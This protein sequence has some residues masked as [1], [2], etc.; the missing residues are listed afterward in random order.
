[1]A[2]NSTSK[3]LQI[4]KANSVMIT[5]V[6][7]TSFIVVFSLVA[8]KAL[9]SQRGYQ[10]RVI[11]KKEKAR[12]QLKQNVTESEKLIASYKSFVSTSQNIIGGNPNGT[13]DKD[14][15]SAK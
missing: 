7:I 3:K 12:D 6:A 14:G 4:N 1:M 11:T 10:A 8:S 15:D 13:G 9:L 5:A 2:K